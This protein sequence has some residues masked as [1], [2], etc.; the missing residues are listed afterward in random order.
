M[1]RGDDDDDDDN[2][3]ECN[4]MKVCPAIK[5]WR[6]VWKTNRKNLQQREQNELSSSAVYLDNVINFHS[7]CCC[8]WHTHT[9][10]HSL[11]IYRAIGKTI[12]ALGS[13][14][15]QCTY[16]Y[17]FTPKG[18]LNDWVLPLLFYNWKTWEKAP[19]DAC[20][21]MLSFH[22]NTFFLNFF[23]AISKVFHS[24]NSFNL[25]AQFVEDAEI[26]IYHSWT[27]RTHTHTTNSDT[28]S[29]RHKYISVAGR[30]FHLSELYIIE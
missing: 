21:M 7:F 27:E 3:S 25:C 14:N 8:M 22:Y 5:C 13:F 18:I 19:F 17:T 28:K 4:D 15:G 23:I 16:T 20:M 30:H 6:W 29:K 24:H 10:T 9:H 11:A 12:S 2:N 1:L 26:S